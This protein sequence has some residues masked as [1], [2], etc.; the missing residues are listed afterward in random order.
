LLEARS[1]DRETGA[2][3]HLQSDELQEGNDYRWIYKRKRAG[4]AVAL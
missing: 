2:E 4:T 1:R 3:S